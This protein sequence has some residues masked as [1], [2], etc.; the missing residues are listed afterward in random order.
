MEKR[1]DNPKNILVVRLG[2]MGDVV[3]V[4]PA[5]KNLRLEFPSAHIAWLVEDKLKDLVE[6][7]PGIDEVIVFPRKQLQAKLKHP[8][9]YFKAFSEMR[10]FLGKLREKKYDIALD[11]HGNFKSGFLTY[12]SNAR[13]RIGFSRGHCKEF[14]F[15]FTNVQIAPQQKKMHR[16]DKY[17]NL[18]H[19]LGMKAHYQRPVFSIPDTD[20][21]YIDN[22]VRQAHLNQ[23][24]IAIIHPGTSLFGKYKRWPPKNYARLADRLIQELG[25]SVIFTWGALEYEI[26]EEIISFMHH[27]ATIACKTSS[28]KQL[29]ALL[30]HARLFIGGDTGPTHIASGI[31]IPTIAIFGPKDPVVYAPYDENAVVVKKNIPCSP[32]EKRRCNHVLCISSIAPEDVFHAVRKLN[33][34]SE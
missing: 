7:L 11:F 3:H 30:Q 8:R 2:A 18:L 32:C 21:H 6:G 15:I 24:S 31:G 5:V 34:Y 4:I 19:G 12:L 23:K 26:V 33:Y 27:R 17:L 16:I 25:Y 22:F 1:F 28:V 14:N 29:I 13:V 20:R 10:M 9:K